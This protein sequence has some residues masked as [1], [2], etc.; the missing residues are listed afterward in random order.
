MSKL[1]EAKLRKENND[2][3][4]SLKECLGLIDELSHLE[5]PLF[6]AELPLKFRLH[7]VRVVSFAKKLV[8]PI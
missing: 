8:K 6:E 7:Y 1:I 2:L 3:R 5:K 4:S